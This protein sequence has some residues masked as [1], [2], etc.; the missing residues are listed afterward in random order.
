[1]GYAQ[2][3]TDSSDSLTQKIDTLLSDK[4]YSGSSKNVILSDSVVKEFFNLGFSHAAIDNVQ[5]IEYP[6]ISVQFADNDII[7]IDYLQNEQN[8]VAIIF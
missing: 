1:M 5:E 7:W 6:T 4:Y 3:P 2:F 8:M